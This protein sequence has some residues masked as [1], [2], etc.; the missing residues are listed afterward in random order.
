MKI[1]QSKYTTVDNLPT[2]VP[3]TIIIRIPTFELN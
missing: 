2:K 3:L 1:F